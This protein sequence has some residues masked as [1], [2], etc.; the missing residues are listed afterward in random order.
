MKKCLFVVL[1]RREKRQASPGY[2]GS[3]TGSWSG[4]TGQPAASEN[5]EA[6]STEIRVGVGVWQDGGEDHRHT[7]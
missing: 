1:D 5:V 2:I 7:P 3:A 4:A 6:S